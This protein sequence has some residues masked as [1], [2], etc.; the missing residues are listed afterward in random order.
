MLKHHVGALVDQGACGLGFLGGI[1]PGVDP[2]DLE[3][4]IGVHC[5]SVQVGRVD[6]PDHLGD[7]EGPDVADDVAFGQLPCDVALNGAALVETG[8]IGRHVVG[9]LVAGGVLELHI[10][11]LAGDLDGLVH[12]AERGGKDQ[13]GAIQSHLLH[14][15][16]RV[17][18]LGHAFDEHGL[19]GI[20]EMLFDGQTALVVF[21]GPAAVADGADID[22]PDLER[23]V[24][25]N[26]CRT[27]D[28]RGSG[29]KF[30]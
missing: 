18:S 19:D 11:E 29:K 5:P 4:D 17:R 28:N 20:A 30:R 16:H 22:K 23:I 1:E 14:D 10:R 2:D 25:R 12:V 13:I 27:R 15:V 21:I 7:R 24:L 9:A 8:G 6:A 3:L 26:G